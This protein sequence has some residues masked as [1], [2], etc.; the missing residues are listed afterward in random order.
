MKNR[1]SRTVILTLIYLLLSIGYV[2]VFAPHGYIRLMDSYDVL[3]HMNRIAS[4]GNIFTSPVN[5]DYWGHVGNMTS[6][7]YPWLMILPGFVI[8]QLAGNPV[9]GYLIFLGIIT[10][11]T[12]ASSYFFMKKF[13]SDTLQSFLFS[14]FYTLAFFRMASIFYRAGLAEFMC[15]MFIPM[16]FF[17]FSE[18][19]SG[20]FNK[21]PWFALSFAMILL[22]HPLTAF[23]TIFL[24]IPPVILVLFSKKSHSW[25][26]WW[27]L[28]LSG[29][30]S[31]VMVIV[32]TIGFTVPMLQQQRALSVN[33]PANLN[34]AST[35]KD[36]IKMI[37]DAL[38]TD[39]RSY[40]F[41][42]IMILA[43]IL[44]VIFFW[45]DK[46][47]YKIIGI[48]MLLSL[49]ISTSIIPWKNFQ[50]TFF[51]YLQFPWRFLNLFTFFAAIYLSYI[52]AKLVKQRSPFLKLF[53]MIFVLAACGTQVYISGDQLNHAI[54]IAHPNKITTAD[55]SQQVRKFHQEDYYP[56]ESLPY[57]KEIK[58]GWSI[59]NGNK[60]K[61]DH[62]V[63]AN[64]Y[65]L[66]YFNQKSETIDLPIL[67]Y[68]GL[69][70]IINNETSN[71]KI[72]D[73]GTVQFKT[74]PGQ[75]QIQVKYDY[76]TI[77][78]LSLVVSGIA[79]ILLLWLCV[80]DGKILPQKKIVQSGSGNQKR[81]EKNIDV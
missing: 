20:K 5:F 23:T 58:Q 54:T 6:I 24:L 4:L 71:F 25:K 17:E 74:K 78:K 27:H 73:R 10:F 47:K 1:R 21:W 64:T 53:M 76:T 57:K 29:L 26:Y 14:I 42:I 44:V 16:L 15:Y 80:N 77:A 11:L 45:T 66:S 79:L 30:L 43:I 32:A 38:G 36:P 9:V 81:V 28:F 37:T 68:R 18:L 56:M 51:N 49:I 75:N 33:R 39:L 12:F 60:M 72:S 19:L 46:L 22:T 31:I 40:S 3:F 67:V 2:Y 52:F 69:H 35:A 55:A 48:E 8:F 61:L 65:S 13:S 70:L 41:G 7:F 63:Q 59:V 50:N 34:L 62:Q